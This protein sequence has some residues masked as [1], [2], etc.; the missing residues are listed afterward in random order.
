MVKY[1]T[2]TWVVEIDGT[3]VLAYCKTGTKEFNGVARFSKTGK[4]LG[5]SW[6]SAEQVPDYVKKSIVAR[7]KK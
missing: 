6:D 1:T 4:F 2:G 7:L 5:T 3:K